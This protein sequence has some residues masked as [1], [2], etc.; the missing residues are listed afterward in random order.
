MNMNPVQSVAQTWHG[1][2]R[3][4]CLWLALLA[5]ATLGAA[6][7]SIRYPTQFV[8]GDIQAFWCGGAM[9]LLHANPYVNQPLHACEA[10]HS[11][12]F[13]AA[14]PNVTTPAP[15]P[16][17]AL[18]LFAPLSLIP[19]PQARTLWWIMLV[20]AAFAVGGGI[21][22]LTGIPTITAIAASCLAVLGPAIFPGALG[23]IPVALTVFAALALRQEQWTRAAILLGFAMIEPHV[24]LPACVATFAFV[25]KMRLRLIAAGAIAILVSFALVG[26]RVAMSY[27]TTT[28]PIHA[29]SEVNNLAQ[30]SLAAML[31]H[32]GVAPKL[33]VLVGSV[34]YAVLAIASVV[35]AGRLWRTYADRSWLVLV[36]AA[37]AVVGGAFIHLDQVAMVI[38]LAWMLA[39][40]RPSK[41]A[42]GVL[43]MLA[44]PAEI[45]INWLPFTIP[46][47]L[48]CAWLVAQAKA[49]WSVVVASSLAV[50][51][52]TCAMIAVLVVGNHLMAVSGHAYAVVPAMHISD[53]GPNA[54]ASETWG[55]YLS[56]AVFRPWIWWPEKLLTLAP[57]VAV[58]FLALA[59]SAPSSGSS[60]TA[61]ARRLVC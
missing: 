17:Y 43:M 42:F 51:I 48:I 50:V 31:Y 58:L 9:L 55:R 54:S 38:P 59:D 37:F 34:Q 36:P 14:Y 21:A 28:L 22:K 39:L 56:F 32:L 33:A 13:Y 1:L 41:T 2:D 8:G 47:A 18:A 20:I 52:A 49:H 30:Y 4:V 24:V 7:F 10:L 61:A 6:Y 11:L 44:M 19:Y 16:P 46:A 53:P 40:K 3:R 25:P 29:L 26:P 60:L 15:L 23:P 27:F 45:L 35:V 12:R 5:G 57:V